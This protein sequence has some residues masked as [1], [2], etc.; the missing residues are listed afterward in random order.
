VLN[1]YD[2]LQVSPGATPDVIHAAYRVLA[3]RVHPDVSTDPEA[4]RAMRRLNAAYQVLGDP[5]R[6]ARYD[7]LLARRAPARAAVISAGPSGAARRGQL[8]GAASTA[9]TL[10][11]RTSAG[12]G[13]AQTQRPVSRVALLIAM[14]ALASVVL[15]VFLWAVADEL[16]SGSPY[17]SPPDPP[18]QLVFNRG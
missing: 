18:G 5:A 1:L 4:P 14:I 2:V 3:R 9:R 8:V 11:A 12:P 13:R 16:D 17:P 6:R 10:S 15:L 7:A